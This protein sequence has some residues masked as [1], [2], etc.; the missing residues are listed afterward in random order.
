M[1]TQ[2]VEAINY[3]RNVS[4]KKVAIDKIVTYFNNAGSSNWDKESLEANLKK[5][6]TKGVVNENY[7]PLITLSYNSPDSSI[8]QNDVFITPQVDHDLIS[9]STNVVIPI[10]ISDPATATPTIGSFVN[11]CTPQLFRS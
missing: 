3:V 6:Q 7:K 2:M 11:P 10:Q 4:K 9:A 5:M 8:I 1:D